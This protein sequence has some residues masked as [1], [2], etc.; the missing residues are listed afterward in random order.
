MNFDMNRTWSQAVALIRTNFQLLAIVAGMFVL[1][2]TLAFYLLNPEL[3]AVLADAGKPGQFEGVLQ[4]AM[5]RLL[6]FGLA[7]FVVQMIGQG[8][9]VSLV[10]QHRPTVG[11]AIRTG[12]RSLPSIVAAI[13][14]FIAGL[15]L[16][17]LLLS[18]PLAL[19]ALLLGASARG[20]A[21]ISAGPLGSVISI[22]V[23]VIELY[24]MVRFM[25]TLPVIVLE[26][27]LN[28]VKAMARSWRL[29]RPCAWRVLAF[30]VLLGV[31]YLVIVLL[32]MLVLGAV[33]LVTG[34]AAANGQMGA[35][36]ALGFAVVAAILGTAVAMLVAAI[37]VSLHRQLAGGGEAPDVEFDA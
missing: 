3:L 29:T 21:A 33:G 30:V 9:L 17:L 28:P 25:M 8:A 20:A 10:G 16:A 34:S 19:I 35:A 22:V 5:P 4:A 11:E 23:F 6:A 7:V 26:H 14:L 24:L 32:A 15:W 2:P 18:L 31:A 36:S 27:Q 37:L 13:I 12:V 1:L